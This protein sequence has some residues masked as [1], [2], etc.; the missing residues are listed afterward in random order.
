MEWEAVR[1]EKTLNFSSSTTIK[2]AQPIL[3]TLT[4]P[5]PDSF[6]ASFLIFNL[7]KNR[8]FSFSIPYSS[9][10]ARLSMYLWNVKCCVLPGPWDGNKFFFSLLSTHLHLQLTLS[11]PSRVEKSRL[12][13]ENFLRRE[14]NGKKKCGAMVRVEAKLWWR[15]RCEQRREIF[16]YFSLS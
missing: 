9:F 8:M 16:H 6:H 15:E 10:G 1:R 3:L 7:F 2:S 13:E 11:S 5:P 12:E 4:Q 14:K